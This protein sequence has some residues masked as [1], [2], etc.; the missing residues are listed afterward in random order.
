MKKLLKSKLTEDKVKIIGEA[1][2]GIE[3]VEFYKINCPELVFMDITMPN[4]NGIEA[5]REIIKI[6]K[7]AKVVM[8]SAMG[9]QPFIT[10]SIESGAKDFIIKPFNEN[11]LK[12]VLNKLFP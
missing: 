8:C 2:D 10:E 7:D 12:E 6:N 5:L 1:S 11:K 9:Q 4:M 3:A